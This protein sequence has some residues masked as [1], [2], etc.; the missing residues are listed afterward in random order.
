MNVCER[1]SRERVPVAEL[2]DDEF[3]HAMDDRTKMLQ[4]AG[5]MLRRA[6]VAPVFVIRQAGKL[7]LIQGSEQVA[8]ADELGIDE[9]DAIVF[10]ALSD[11]EAD[12]VGTVGFDLAELGHDV[13]AGLQSVYGT[14]RAA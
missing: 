8:A 6:P 14:T 5:A 13:W 12:H 2:D 4:F 3:L 10:D 11:A 1:I 9:L 7:S